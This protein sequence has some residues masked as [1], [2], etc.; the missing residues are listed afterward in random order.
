[1]A[2]GAGRLLGDEIAFEPFQPPRRTLMGPGPSN[3]PDRVLAAMA[4]PTIGHLDPEFVGMMEEVKELLRYAFQT[5]NE[6]TFPVSGP[7]SVG[8][9]A[10]FVN[11]LEPGDKAV[12]CRNGVFGGRMVENVERCGGVPVVVDDEWGRPVSLEKVEAALAANPDTRLVAFVQAETSTGAHTD[13]APLVALAHEHGCLTIVDTVT[14]VG[15]VPV[16]ADEWD[17]DVVYAGTQKCLSCPPGLAP[18]SFGERALARVRARATRCQS[19]FMDLN[20]QLGYWSAGTRT[21]HH[22]APVNALYGLHESLLLLHEEGL[23]AAWLRHRRNHEALVAGFDAM[24]LRQ[25]VA[26]ADRLPQLNMVVVPE[27]IDEATVRQR[28]LSEFD[29][30]V[31]AGLGALSGKVWRVGLMGY[32]CSEASVLHCL[33]AYESVLSD[34]GFAVTGGAGRRAAR[35]RLVSSTAS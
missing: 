4:R 15:G 17:I 13:P 12:V 28:L 3:V 16:R 26:A 31:G 7:G 29:L 6:M 21:Y 1:M 32:T 24:G 25:L 22:T 9:E 5:R 10:C 8:M 35:E 2:A 23:E 20:L 19:W 33:D 30:E 11:L 34:L 27:G 18:V 14:A